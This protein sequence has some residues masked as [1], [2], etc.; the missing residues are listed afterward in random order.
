METRT[1]MPTAGRRMFSPLASL[2]QEM[3]KL[4]NEWL[5]SPDFEPTHGLEGNGGF[6]PRI[7]VAEREHALEVTAELPGV[8]RNDIEIELT[9][10]A[11]I[12]KGQKNV[13]MEEKREGYLRRERSHSSMSGPVIIRA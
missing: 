1:L 10:T 6:M 8:E 7:N 5:A 13:E 3:D 12:L 11:L 9:K 4:F 2:R